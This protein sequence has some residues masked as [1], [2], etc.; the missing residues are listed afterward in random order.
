MFKT[1][2]LYSPNSEAIYHRNTFRFAYKQV[3]YLEINLEK[4]TGWESGDLISNSGSSIY[5][6]LPRTT[7]VP[8][9]LTSIEKKSIGTKTPVSTKLWFINSIWC[10]IFLAQPR[11]P[12]LKLILIKKQVTNLGIYFGLC[13]YGCPKENTDNNLNDQSPCKW[14]SHVDTIKSFKYLFFYTLTQEICEFQTLVVWDEV[15]K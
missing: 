3:N 5:A 12:S 8:Q 9:T 4:D 1:V 13:T 6:T 14:S 2:N 11:W 7:A 10:Y 15:K